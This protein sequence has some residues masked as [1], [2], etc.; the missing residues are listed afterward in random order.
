[1]VSQG[2]QWVSQGSQRGAA[3]VLASLFFKLRL[4]LAAPFLL[5]GGLFLWLCGGDG[6][7]RVAKGI[8]RFAKGGR[9]GG[10]SPVLASLFLSFACFWLRRFCCL[11]GCAGEM[12]SQGTQWV[13]QGSQRG[14][15]PALASLFFTVLDWLHTETLRCTETTALGGYCGLQFKGMISCVA[16]SNL[17]PRVYPV[18]AAAPVLASLFFK[19]RLFLAAP[20]LLLGGLFWGNG[21]ARNAMGIARLAKGGRK[22]GRLCRFWLRCFFSFAC[23]WLRRFCCL[24]GC[25]GEMVSQGTQWVSQGSQRGASPAAAA[26]FF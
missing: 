5:L 2:T 19:L 16:A 13:S 23:F 9:K 1:M 20:F 8:A 24:G 17:E 12:V 15:S 21:I 7:A 25:A 14:A 11:G 26:P 10:A 22:G 3:P 6:I 18:A 4:F